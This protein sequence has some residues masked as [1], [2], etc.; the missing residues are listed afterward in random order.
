MTRPRIVLVLAVVAVLVRIA[1]VAVPASGVLEELKPLLVERCERVSVAPGTEDVTFD[2]ASGLAFVSAADRRGN[3][4]GGIY[5]LDPRRPDSLRLVST[6]APE[7][8]HPHGISLWTGAGGERRLFVVNHPAAGGHTVEIFDVAADS[9]DEPGLRHVETVAYPALSSPNDVLA[10]GPRAFYATNDRAWSDSPLE[11][12]EGYL[13]LP[14]ASVS[15]FDGKEG[16]L[17]ARGIAFANGINA[18]P[19]GRTVYVAEVLGRRVRVYE[20]DQASG[21]LEPRRSLPVPTAPDN[22]EVA[23]DGTL[24]IGGHPRIFDFLAHA[25]DPSRTAPSHVVR[26]DPATG[27]AETVLVSLAGELSASSVAAV[28]DDVLVVGAVF[29]GHVLVCPLR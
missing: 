1:M 5:L 19:D 11:M 2:P 9:D 22:I 27:A 7:D 21:D 24:W 23:A 10:V 20:R 25:D 6:D 28:H 8:F 13:G 29:D 3:A 16:R 12:V 14:I 18:S 17:V 4:R 26:V 15:Y